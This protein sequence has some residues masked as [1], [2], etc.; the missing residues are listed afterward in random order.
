MDG[1]STFHIGE[2]T[3]SSSPSHMVKLFQICRSDTKV[4]KDFPNGDHNNTVAEPEYFSYIDNF[5][6]EYVAR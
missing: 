5:L 2:L 4:W 3:S 1:D 6:K